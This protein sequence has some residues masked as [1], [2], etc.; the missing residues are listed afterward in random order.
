M[1]NVGYLLENV[2]SP[3]R[4]AGLLGLLTLVSFPNI[5]LCG[6]KFFAGDFVWFGYPLAFYHKQAFWRAEFLGELPVVWQQNNL[7]ETERHSEKQ[8]LA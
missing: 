4:F 1:S 3:G 8:L 5:L 2:L 7:L 6:Q